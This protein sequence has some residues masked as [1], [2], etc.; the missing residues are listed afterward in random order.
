MKQN[1]TMPCKDAGKKKAKESNSGLRSLESGVFGPTA[2]L[3]QVIDRLKPKPKQESDSAASFPQTQRS[4]AEKR[5]E[6]QGNKKASTSKEI[7]LS[8]RSSLK[9]AH[10]ESDTVVNPGT[11]NSQKNTGM[12]YT[13]YA[14]VLLQEG[15]GNSHAAA[16]YSKEALESAIPLFEGAKLYVN[17]PGQAEEE[18]RPERNVR[19]VLGYYEDIHV[20]ENDRGQAELRGNLVTMGGESYA[21]ARELMEHAVNYAQKYIGKAFVGLSINAL[22]DAD[23][24]SIEEVLKKGVPKGALAK[25]EEAKKLG[26]ETLNYVSKFTDAISCDLVTEAGAGGKFT[27][28]IEG[29]KTMNVKKKATKAKESAIEKKESDGTTGD[30]QAQGDHADAAEDVELIKKMLKKHLGVEEGV[31][32]TDEEVSVAKEAYEAHIEM[33]SSTEEAEGKACEFLKASKHLAGKKAAKEAADKE[34]SGSDEGDKAS[35]EKSEAAVEEKKESVEAEEKKES[36]EKKESAKLSAEVARLKGEL[37]S[38]KE[39]AKKADLKSHIEKVC[40]E[41]KLSNTVTGEFKKLVEGAKSVDEVNATFKIFESGY[42]TRS[43]GQGAD[44]L[45]FS[46]MMIEGEKSSI[47][48]D[49]SQTLDFNSCKID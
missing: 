32:P 39:S 34:Q 13:K 37:A 3:V 4:N 23:E 28:L 26:I 15:M 8:E 7:R 20:E 30:E 42:K 35:E 14:V 19:D 1:N 17:H 9:T 24:I 31:E 5:T 12:G 16:Y 41:S 38:F 46:S 21:W 36:S 10:R 22:G 2:Y 44:G 49:D 45:D 43:G 18:D 27:E 11:P 6:A 29:A 33:G 40:K 48:S 47:M 25:I